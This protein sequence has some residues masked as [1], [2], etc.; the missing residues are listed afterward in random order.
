M[1]RAWHTVAVLS[2]RHMEHWLDCIFRFIV[3]YVAIVMFT[4]SFMCVF[5]LFYVKCTCG[6]SRFVSGSKKSKMK[7][8]TSGAQS[9]KS[10]IAV[11]VLSFTTFYYVVSYL[12]TYLF[13]RT[14]HKRPFTRHA[15]RYELYVYRI[16]PC[17]YLRRSVATKEDMFWIS[18]GFLSA[19]EK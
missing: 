1:V 9:D 2:I 19:V 18:R 4:I 7:K 6:V 13:F 17:C 3:Y 8:L 15:G 16:G 12:L 14:F 10:R 5:V 11:Q